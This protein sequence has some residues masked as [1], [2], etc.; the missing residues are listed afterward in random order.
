MLLEALSVC[1]GGVFEDITDWGPRV[2][3]QLL[4]R[5]R[6]ALVLV[7]LQITCSPQPDLPTMGC[8]FEFPSY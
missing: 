1:E 2:A 7:R 4:E 3:L 6:R 5:H 8:C